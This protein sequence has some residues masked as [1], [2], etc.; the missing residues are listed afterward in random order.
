ML[1]ITA[2]ISFEAYAKEC[3]PLLDFDVRT[4]NDKTMVNL[5]EAYQGKVIMIVNTASKCAYTDQYESLEKLYQQY[6]DDGLV[7]LG[8]PSNDFGQ[9]E[10]GNEYQIKTF[11][12]STYGV[13]FPMFAKTRVSERN[14][15]PLY[16]ELASAAGTY[17][18]WN[19]HKYLIDRNGELVASYRS[20]IDPLDETVI[21]EIKKQIRKF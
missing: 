7:V 10:P 8:F 12:R 3:S 11:C 2:L 21:G 13:R 14:A 19:F 15:D 20:A 4:L 18:K 6:S 1:L 9:Q 5:C 17:P 16:K